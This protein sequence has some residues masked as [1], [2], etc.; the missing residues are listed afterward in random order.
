LVERQQ[1]LPVLRQKRRGN[2]VAFVVSHR[3]ATADLS[4]KFI[5]PISDPACIE[6]QN[7][8]RAIK[9]TP[10]GYFEPECAPT[11]LEI[12]QRIRPGLIGH[13]RTTLCQIATSL[14][15]ASFETEPGKTLPVTVMYLPTE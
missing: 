3:Q 4:C 9:V 8:G 14:R 11:F 15:S 13:A 2:L 1:L 12:D 6:Q 5:Q 7:S 10:L